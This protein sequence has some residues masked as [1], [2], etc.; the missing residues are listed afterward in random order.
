MPNEVTDTLALQPFFPGSKLHFSEFA[1]AGFSDE[2]LSV[3]SGTLPL[4][5]CILASCIFVLLALPKIFKILPFLFGGVFR[6]REAQHLADSPKL[7]SDCKIAAWA[8][9]FPVVFVVARFELHP[10]CEGLQPWEGLLTSAILLA[11]YVLVRGIIRF[12]ARPGRESP[13]AADAYKF[14]SAV[15]AM[16]YLLGGMLIILTAFFGL[17]FSVEQT[18][19]RK[20]MYWEM[21]VCYA[22]CI[23]R[24]TQ[25][26]MYYRGFF[27]GFLYLCTLE[28]IPTGALMLSAIL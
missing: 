9:S 23:L 10:R 15:P 17:A 1:G 16:F 24:R 27:S 14:A 18:L 20:V 25:I 5:I 6:W 4:S 7:H 21:G 26:F 19:I 11:A 12:I 8:I 22:F 13:S 2:P 28:I 3:W